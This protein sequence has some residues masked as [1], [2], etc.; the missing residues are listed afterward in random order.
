MVRILQ[1]MRSTPACNVFKHCGVAGYPL[2]LDS[3]V[4]TTYVRDLKLR[5]FE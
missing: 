2:Q 5:A 3:G 4:T 1:R